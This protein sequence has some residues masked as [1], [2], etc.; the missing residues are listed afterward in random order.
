MVLTEAQQ[1]IIQSEPR[2]E[3]IIPEHIKRIAL[4]R[5]DLIKLWDRFRRETGIVKEANRNF[6]QLYNSG[7]F[8]S[9]IFKLFLASRKSSIW[10]LIF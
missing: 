10:K 6:L 7:E 3:K 1:E 9:N 2:Q 5:L 4:A 8:H